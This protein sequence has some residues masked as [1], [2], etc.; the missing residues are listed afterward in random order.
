MSGLFL[1][2]FPGN[3]NVIE[4]GYA[5]LDPL[6]LIAPWLFL[7]LVP[8]VTMRMFAEEKSSGTLELLLTRPLTDFQVIWA[9]YLAGLTLVVFAILPTLLYFLSVY[10]LADPVGN[11]D[12]AGT[13]GSYIGL[14]F[15]SA[16]YVAI[17]IFA[18]SLTSNQ[19]ISF[20]T[21][22]LLCFVVYLGFDY[23]ASAIA[24]GSISTVIINLG[25]NE[26]YEA[27]SRGVLDSR[28]IIYFVS[29]I[30]IFLFSTK[31][32]LQSRTWK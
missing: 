27:M 22:V 19:I 28:D 11:M 31:I 1:W 32:V 8:A 3:M 9:K 16:I 29:V 24:S 5:S 4:G 30:A 21:A 18:S 10:L 25:I 12:V 13:W 20:I 15:L 17:G 14:L 7:F 23:I 2:V 6:F 26:H